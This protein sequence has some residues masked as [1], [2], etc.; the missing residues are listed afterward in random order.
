MAPV[1]RVV[2]VEAGSPLLSDYVALTDVELRR[3]REPAEGLFIA[4]G[5]KVIRRAVEA[6][7]PIRSV[8]LEEKWLPGLADLLDRADVPAYVASR[9]TLEAVTGYSVHRGALAA[10]TRLPLPPVLELAE[11]SQRVVVLEDLVDHTNVGAVMRGAAGLGVDA[12]LVTPRCADPLYRRAVKVSMGAVFAVPWTR[13]VAWP[14]ALEDLR[15]LGFSVLA[16]TPAPDATP[17]AD[18]P[19]ELSERCA[20]VLGTEGEG[21]SPGALA[22]CDLRV[23]IPMAPGVDSLNVAAAAAVACYA[24]GQSRR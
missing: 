9:A 3:T 18:I 11:R 24:L 17:L 21:V 7:Y 15:D 8:L 20:L 23:R 10:M 2:T 16:L 22:A 13:L 6:G 19:P 5:E 4:E 1:S 12:V 14:G